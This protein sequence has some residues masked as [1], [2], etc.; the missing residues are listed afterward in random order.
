MLY[1]WTHLKMHVKLF[2]ALEK[3]RIYSNILIVLKIVYLPLEKGLFPV[4]EG[5]SVY[6]TAL[7]YSNNSGSKGLPINTITH[8]TVHALSEVSGW[9]ID[10]ISRVQKSCLIYVYDGGRK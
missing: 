7:K 8:I 6:F 4:S 2:K 5:G 10:L 9:H 3:M 1:I